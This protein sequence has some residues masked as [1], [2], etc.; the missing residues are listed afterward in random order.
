MC[1]PTSFWGTARAPR[2]S[3]CWVTLHRNGTTG[4]S[5]EQTSREVSLLLLRHNRGLRPAEHPLQETCFSKISEGGGLFFVFQRPCCLQR[6]VSPHELNRGHHVLPTL[7]PSSPGQPASCSSFG[8]CHLFPKPL[9]IR[10]AQ[11]LHFLA[12][13][14]RCNY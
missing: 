5:L 3:L 8:R 4:I 1:T 6:E 12:Q 9:V 13:W 11:V 10:Q 2:A 14:Q 7:P